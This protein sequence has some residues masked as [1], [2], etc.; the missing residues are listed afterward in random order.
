VGERYRAPAL[1]Q[2]TL[3]GIPVGIQ[4]GCR[5][6]APSVHQTD[7]P[8]KAH[9]TMSSTYLS[10]WRVDRGPSPHKE[11]VPTPTQ[12]QLDDLVAT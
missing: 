5:P 9:G 4:A 10:A 11:R 1:P 3:Y 6:D 12:L 2:W 8:N 7:V